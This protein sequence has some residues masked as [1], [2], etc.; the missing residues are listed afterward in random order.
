M[1]HGLSFN[2]GGNLSTPGCIRGL[3]RLWIGVKNPLDQDVAVPLFRARGRNRHVEH[4][5]AVR[6]R[7]IV[8]PQSAIPRVAGFDAA[9]CSRVVNHPTTSHHKSHS[10]GRWRIGLADTPPSPRT[11]PRSATAPRSG[12]LTNVGR[13]SRPAGRRRLWPSAGRAAAS[14]QLSARRSAT[15]GGGVLV[16]ADGTTA[17]GS[18][19][20]RVHA[21]ANTAHTAP[22]TTRDSA[23][24][25]RTVD[26]RN[27][28]GAEEVAR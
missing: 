25:F 21:A 4:Q 22:V 16:V 1:S 19:T 7:P 12:P 3:R 27:P 9:G 10:G 2:W 6:P 15:T 26:I 5:R 14:V 17:L 20:C 8:V 18:G 13:W 23:T 28:V 24:N 11:T